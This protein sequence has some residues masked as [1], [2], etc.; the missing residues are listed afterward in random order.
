VVIA[1]LSNAFSIITYTVFLS[2]FRHTNSDLVEALEFDYGVIVGIINTLLLIFA[3]LWIIRNGLVC[4][5]LIYWCGWLSPQDIVQHDLEKY[6][7]FLTHDWGEDELGRNNHQRV[8]AINTLLKKQGFTTWFD[9]DR[10]RGQI[11]AQI[12]S[13]LDRAT[14]VVVFVTQRYCEKVKSGNDDYCAQEFTYAMQ[15][16]KVNKMVSVVME[17][18]MCDQSLW[19]GPV[20]MALGGRL[21]LNCSKDEENDMHQCVSQ[22][23]NLAREA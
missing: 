4:G 1:G 15:H 11:M 13:G 23:R 16:K 2:S 6:D 12:A 14:W 21:Y 18:R 5:P 8:S 9:E 20:G 3:L 22:L 10:L 19:K 17:P 7:F